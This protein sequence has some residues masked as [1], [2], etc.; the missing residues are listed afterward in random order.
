M[1]K[2]NTQMAWH[3]VAQINFIFHYLNKNLLTNFAAKRQF[4][5]TVV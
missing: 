2:I 5:G 1:N 4:F 3:M